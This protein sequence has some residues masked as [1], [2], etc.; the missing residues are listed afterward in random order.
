MWSYE[1]RFLRHKIEKDFQGFQVLP[2]P[3]AKPSPSKAVS[4]TFYEAVLHWNLILKIRFQCSKLCSGKVKT[5]KKVSQL[6]SRRTC[7]AFP[8]KTPTKVAIKDG[9]IKMG[10]IKM[11][12]AKMGTPDMATEV[13]LVLQ[14]SS[15][16]I[17]L[18]FRS[19]KPCL[20]T[21]PMMILKH[22]P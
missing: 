19:I 17:D 16:Q 2:Q 3:H 6:M 5:S 12:D 20:L 10:D 1:V 11:E 9:D 13:V 8:G 22:Q 15:V 18:R 21:N 14:H 7:L 4:I